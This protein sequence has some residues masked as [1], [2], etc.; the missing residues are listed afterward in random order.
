MV[1]MGVQ[2]M[3]N[4]LMKKCMADMHVPPMSGA[5]STPS[6]LQDRAGVDPNA[7]KCMK[8]DPDPSCIPNA[9]MDDSP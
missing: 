3:F 5:G 1:P 8:G 6:S 2:G 4:M 9:Y 7:C